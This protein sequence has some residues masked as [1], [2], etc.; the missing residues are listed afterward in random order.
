M[1]AREVPGIPG[2]GRVGGEEG[3]T[4]RKKR[5]QVL[6]A[7]LDDKNQICGSGWFRKLAG[8]TEVAQALIE[9]TILQ[10]RD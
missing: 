4:V 8:I 5:T 3:N 9:S 2:S 7:F 6:A 10:P 1:R